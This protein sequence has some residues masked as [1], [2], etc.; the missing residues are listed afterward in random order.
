MKSIAGT[1]ATACFGMAIS[2]TGARAECLDEIRKAGVITSGNGVMGS[3]PTVWQ[4]LDGSYSGFEWDLFQELAKRIGA[5][6]PEY[7][8]TEWTSLI[9][10][11]KARRWDII[12]SG[13]AA[14]Q[15]RVQGAGITYSDP[16]FLLY[17]FVIVPTNSSINGLTDLKGKTLGSTLGTMDS[18]NAHLMQDEGKAANVLDFNTFGDPFVALRNRQ[19]DAVI[20][21]QSALLGQLETM[22]DLRTI[23]EPIYYHPKPQWADAE[24]AAPYI[25]GST[26]IGVRKECPDLLRAI[27]TALESMEADGT[28]KAI[29]MKY[30]VWS[31]YQARLMK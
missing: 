15:E 10:G 28:R 1:L 30:G 29:L 22:H 18:I 8:V 11:L 13:M 2:L 24:S 26:A 19:V 14:T 25:L 17:D 31:D 5:G 23:G 9:P 21:D 7:I 3:K 27:N 6:K 4:N 20:L 12:F 16:Y